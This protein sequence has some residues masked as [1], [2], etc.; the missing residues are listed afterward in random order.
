MEAI[1][2]LVFLMILMLIVGMGGAL[3]YVLV[4]EMPNILDDLTEAKKAWKKK[5]RS[6]E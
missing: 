3:L 2:V 4:T 1:G 6:E 5:F